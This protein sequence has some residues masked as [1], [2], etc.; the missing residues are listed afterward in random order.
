MIPRRQIL[1]TIAVVVARGRRR[2]PQMRVATI[3]ARARFI[4]TSRSRAARGDTDMD[5]PAH[6]LVAAV[7]RGVS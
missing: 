4:C 1:I 7:G 6:G 5:P 3:R 2:V